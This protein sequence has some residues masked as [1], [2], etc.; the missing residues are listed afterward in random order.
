MPGY[1]LPFD[2]TGETY[3]MSETRSSLKDLLLLPLGFLLNMSPLWA[4][5]LMLLI[6]S[7]CGFLYYSL[8]SDFFGLAAP[9]FAELN[10]SP[11][12]TSVRD[13]KDSRSWKITYESTPFSTF[14]GVVRHVSNWRDEPIPFATHDIL[15]TT[16]EF[17]SPSRVPT[18]VYNHAFYYQYDLGPKPQGNINL[19]H[20]VPQTEQI[21]RQLLGVREWNLVTI[22]GREI[23]RIDLFDS[24]GNSTY[25]WQ[26]EGCNSILVTS[27]K[28]EALGTPI[29]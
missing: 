9:P 28:I 24:A 8:N 5:T 12:F 23:Y 21:Y 19:L 29:P 18:R 27:V 1:N 15:V 2:V 4:V 7:V 17:S 3:C 26:D 10:F 16:G 14:H 25:Y 13:T 22:S 11:D 6:V 20:I